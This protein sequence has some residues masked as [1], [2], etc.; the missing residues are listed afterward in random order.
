MADR[1]ERIDSKNAALA[2]EIRR[3]G[4]AIKPEADQKKYIENPKTQQSG[5]MCCIPQQ[6]VC[7]IGCPDCFFQSGRSYLEPLDE[8]LP[9]MPSLAEAASCVVRVND[10]ND[11]NNQR[12]LVMAAVRKYPMRFYNTSIPHGLE[13][14]DAPV[15]L[16]VN[17]S[18]KT[19][20]SAALLD[21]IPPNL[22]FVRVRTNTWNLSLV[23]QVVAHYTQIRHGSDRR[24]PVVLTFMAYYTESI[25]KGHEADYTFRKRTMNSYWVIT[26]EAWDRAMDR[27]YLN[28]WVYTCGKDANTFACHRC[29]NCLREY[30]ATMRRLKVLS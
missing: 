10:G 16:T 18:E 23:D 27:Y 12:D 28:P 3:Q 1:Q 15:V 2:K 29:G 14:F 11:S 24:V 6:G 20:K 8:H 21:P 13:K 17:P 25:P 19:D 5:V 22:M 7:P 9:N 4:L 30:F 26:Q